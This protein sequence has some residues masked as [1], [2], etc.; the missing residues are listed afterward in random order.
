MLNSSFNQIEEFTY[1]ALTET[2][3]PGLLL[4]RGRLRLSCECRF[5]NPQY[6]FDLAVSVLIVC[7]RKWFS[8]P[9]LKVKLRK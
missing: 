5:V 1:T 3:C 2:C 8:S 9:T 4:A 7:V 6:H